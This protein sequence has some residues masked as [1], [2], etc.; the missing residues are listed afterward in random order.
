MSYEEKVLT[1]SFPEYEQYQRDT[2]R[3]IPWLY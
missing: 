2:A 3:I 1:E